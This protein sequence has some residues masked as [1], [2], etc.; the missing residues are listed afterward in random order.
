MPYRVVDADG[1]IYWY[2][3]EPPG[4]DRTGWMH[5]ARMRAGH[6][7]DG[8]WHL[9]LQ[10]RPQAASVPPTASSPENDDD[11]DDGLDYAYGPDAQ[12]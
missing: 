11:G 3:R 9:S 2:Q 10:C 6:I 5:S 4:Y 1:T 8:W 7:A 12:A